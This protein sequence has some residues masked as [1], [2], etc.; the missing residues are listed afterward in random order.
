M[1]AIQLKNAI[2]IVSLILVFVNT[3]K[4][5]IQPSP[6]LSGK[7]VSISCR[8]STI[9]R[10]SDLY[11]FFED[12]ITLELFEKKKN[13]PTTYKFDEDKLLS[14]MIK[15]DVAKTDNY[16]ESTLPKIKK[17]RM[18]AAQGSDTMKRIAVDENFINL[19]NSGFD[20]KYLLETSDVSSYITKS[21]PTDLIVKTAA[22]LTS[23]QLELRKSKEEQLKDLKR[24]KLMERNGIM[25]LVP[26]N[27]HK[28]IDY[29]VSLRKDPVGGE[30]ARNIGLSGIFSF[31]VINNA[32][33]RMAF[34]YSLIGNLAVMSILLTRNMPKLDV[35]IGMDRN[36][37][38]NWS[39]VSFQTA[40]AITFLFAI[41]CGLLAAGLVSFLPL[42]VLTKVKASLAMSIVGSSFFTSFFEV[43]EEKSKPGWRWKRA[44]EG[45]LSDDVQEQ[46]KRQIFGERKLHDS[47]NFE[48][49]PEV[50]DFPPRPKYV[51][52]VDGSSA[53]GGSGDVD[54]DES[55]IHFA[56]WKEARKDARRA[57]I[58]EVSPE[59]PWVGSK[60]GMYVSSVP[61][62][63]NNAYQKNVLKANKWR[64]KPTKFV[65]D[66]SEFEPV[67]GPIGF[68][69]K[70]PE[71]LNL[72][73]T[74]I[75][76]EKLTASRKA[77]RAF[78][79]YRKTMWKIDKQVVL[80]PCDGADK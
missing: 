25:K 36:K 69:D 32:R 18:E 75:W 24:K 9:D 43:F 76:E 73:G 6:R 62:W 37:V 17:Q 20:R 19:M 70:S 59:T 38:V 31:I 13:N 51:D 30:L 60:V 65:K 48:Y 11:N 80:Q 45:A 63:L 40:V 21:P 28:Y 78:G 34:M 55:S 46:L 2:Y 54:E 35:P 16:W 67:L 4:G 33:A 5:L 41:P 77:A 29:V 71:W 1:F 64:G 8:A 61:A 27:L 44:M 72:F 15:L 23:D 58:M 52:E 22:K 3:S 74:G 14:S 10:K 57:P 26:Q 79:S 47:Y 42:A 50:D 7:R 68:R 66:T 56:K 49:D 12:E 39:Q 53:P